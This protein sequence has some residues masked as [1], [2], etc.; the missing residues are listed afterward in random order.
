MM[1]EESSTTSAVAAAASEPAFQDMSAED[2][3]CLGDSYFV[4]E[5]FQEAVD[6]YAAAM[7]LFRDSEVAM[8]V[9]ALH[10]KSAAFYQLERFNDAFNDALQAVELLSK[11]PS[12]LRVGE[13]ELCYRRVGL[14]ALQLK[15]YAEARDA[16]QKAAQLATLNSRQNRAKEYADWIQ[17]CDEKLA[18]KTP[19]PPVASAVT[20]SLKSPASGTAGSKTESSST[21]VSPAPAATSAVSTTTARN[22]TS[23]RGPPAMPKYQYY[24]SDKFVTVSILEARVAEEDLTVDF[25]PKYL[26]VKLRKGGKD[27]TVVAGNLY[28][29]IDVE[30]SKINIK[31]E[32]VLVKLRKAN[33]G[34]EWHELLGKADGSSIKK[35]TKKKEPADNV[36]ATDTVTPEKI[37]TIPKKSDI[38]RPYASHRDWDAIEKIIEEEEKKD[39]PQGDE[40]MNKLFQQIYANASEDT[41]RAMVKSFQT[42]GGTVLSTNWDEVKEKDYEKERPAPDGVEWKTWDNEKLPSEKDDS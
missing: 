40:A 11:K 17:Q 23:V 31:D 5:N 39:K 2:L 26:T 25:E 18:P 22:P 9:R 14:A 16:L 20:P 19:K 41:K 4:D 7:M 32:K 36:N 27:F 35:T 33:D 1:S 3:L 28:S 37:P 10:H 42:S 34:Y 21:L 15:N 29:E 12:G 38:P 24:Q 6:A 30:K 8:H 13:G